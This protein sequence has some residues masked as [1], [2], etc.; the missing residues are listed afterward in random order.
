V[1]KEAKEKDISANI[2]ASLAEEELTDL[3]ER[4]SHL[5]EQLEEMKFRKFHS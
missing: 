1:E 3:K 5:R 2:A 4:K